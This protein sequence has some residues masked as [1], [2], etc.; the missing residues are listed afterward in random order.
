MTPRRAVAVL[1]VGAEVAL[2]GCGRAEPDPPRPENLNL[3]GARPFVLAEIL[4]TYG[5]EAAPFIA[6]IASE[7]A[8][9]EGTP[10]LKVEVTVGFTRDGRA[11][12]EDW[13]FWVGFRDGEPGVLRSE[14]PRTALW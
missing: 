10:A 8:R 4:R 14:G 11:A 9:V 12:M 3:E 7:P 5:R 1:A 6:R 13:T 2:A